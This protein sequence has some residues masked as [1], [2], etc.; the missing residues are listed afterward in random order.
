MGAITVLLNF[1]KN[2]DGSLATTK[3]GY[4]ILD[5]SSQ[6]GVTIGT[7]VDLGQQEPIAYKKRLK[8]FEVSQ[9]LIDKLEPYMHLKRA[10]AAE[11]LLAHPL[12][13]TKKEANLLDVEMKDDHFEKYH[14]R[15]QWHCKRN[16][17]ALRIQGTF[18]GGTNH[19]V[20]KALPGRQH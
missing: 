20:F 18:F 17:K 14:R 4:K 19:F 8:D 6:S 10:E 7:G 12:T 9:E 11:Y 3:D 15:I 16:Q 13:L 2:N 1:H 5:G